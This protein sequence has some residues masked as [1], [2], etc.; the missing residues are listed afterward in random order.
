ME[1]LE[2]VRM[3]GKLA[4]VVSNEVAKKK[5]KPYDTGKEFTRIVIRKVPRQTIALLNFSDI[6]RIFNSVSKEIIEKNLI[7]KDDIRKLWTET[8]EAL[9]KEEKKIKNARQVDIAFQFTV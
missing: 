6:Q 4:R 3:L 2:S 9:L 1:K 8:S 5:G 7:E